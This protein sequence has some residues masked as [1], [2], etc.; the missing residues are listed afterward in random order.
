[1]ERGVHARTQARCSHVVATSTDRTIA[2]VAGRRCHRRRA[3]PVP[4][5][6]LGSGLL[7][8]TKTLSKVML[9]IPYPPAHPP[10][11]PGT[12]QS[13]VGMGGSIHSGCGVGTGRGGADT[14]APT[15]EPQWVMGSLSPWELTSPHLETITEPR[16]CCCLGFTLDLEPWIRVLCSPSWGSGGMG[17]CQPCSTPTCLQHLNTWKTPSRMLVSCCP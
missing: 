5:P 10:G 11:T 7:L 8:P 9:L 13:T 12:N 1:V 3:S 4:L 15:S 17:Q 6:H 14:P 2:P 16:G